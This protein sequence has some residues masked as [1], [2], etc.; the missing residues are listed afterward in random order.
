MCIIKGFL[1]ICKNIVAQNWVKLNWCLIYKKSIYVLISNSFSFLYSKRKNERNWQFCCFPFIFHFFFFFKNKDNN[2]I[3]WGNIYEIKYVLY[4]CESIYKWKF[5]QKWYMYDVCGISIIITLCTYTCLKI[6]WS[7][8][9][10][11]NITIIW[12]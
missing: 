9:I 7:Y 11:I 8:L 3:D 5:T 12:K 2:V 4:I 10:T 1:F 6:D